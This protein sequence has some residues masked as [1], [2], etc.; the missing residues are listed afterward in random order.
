[1][2]VTILSKI[3]C[4][5]SGYKIYEAVDAHTDIDIDLFSLQKGSRMGHPYRNVVGK[6]NPRLQERID[7]SDL[8]HI[9]GDWV[10]HDNYMGVK[11]MHKPVIQTVCGGLFRKK[12]HGGLQRWTM[13]YYDVCALKTAFTPDLLYPEYSNIWTPHPIDSD[14]VPRSW[15][16][17]DPLIFAHSP[18]N[19]SKKGTKFILA[20]F[21]A[22]KGRVNFETRII[23]KVSF[24]EALELRK[25]STIFFDQ[26]KVGFY[27]NSAIE[28]M[29]HGIPTAAWIS[30]EAI[31]QSNGAL[32]NCPVL[33]LPV[34]NIS[35]WAEMLTKVCNSNMEDLS[36]AT[37]LWCDAVHGYK[38]IASQWKK[39]Y[40]SVV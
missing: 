8:I 7:S 2:K 19:T 18:T 1:M 28:A 12:S 32:E 33:T 5:G 27:G 4:A 22:M 21:D 14:E 30:P 20:V 23:S 31:Q 6:S 35:H 38:A 13:D 24:K 10:P 29:Q 37:K 40:E 34:R 16:R 36:N 26:F 15:K 11:I 25:G 9:K 17:S 39:L 3:D